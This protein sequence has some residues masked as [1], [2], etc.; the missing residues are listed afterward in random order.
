MK[1]D[2]LATLL[3]QLRKAAHSDDFLDVTRSRSNFNES[4][5]NSYFGMGS[6]DRRG[7]QFY[8][9]F[10]LAEKWRF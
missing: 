9:F 3:F 5:R 8:D 6:A 7:D 10:N 2:H 1:A 4:R